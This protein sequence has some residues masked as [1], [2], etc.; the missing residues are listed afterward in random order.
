VG[1]IG[2]ESFQHPTDTRVGTADLF[3]GIVVDTSG[4]KLLNDGIDVA[5]YDIIT[6]GEETANIVHSIERLCGAF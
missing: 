2:T 6:A 4:Y 1:N 3:I 5:F